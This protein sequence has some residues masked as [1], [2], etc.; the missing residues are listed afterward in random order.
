[1]CRGN[2]RRGI[3]GNDRLLGGRHAL[4]PLRDEQIDELNEKV[5]AK[6]RRE[7][8]EMRTIDRLGHVTY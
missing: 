2:D 4:S 5:R 6:A 1:M 7:T 3:S 8:V